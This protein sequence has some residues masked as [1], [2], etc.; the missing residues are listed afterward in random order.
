MATEKLREQISAL[1][2]DELPEGEHELLLRRFTTDVELR[3]HWERYH[4][5]GCALR[6]ELPPVDTRGFAD[7]VMAALAEEPAPAERESSLGQSLI[8]GVAGFAVAA[9]VAV[10]AIVGLQHGARTGASSEIVPD[11]GSAQTV[12]FALGLAN[13]AD[14]EGSDPRDQALLQGYHVDYDVKTASSVPHG[15]PARHY[16]VKP[17]VAPDDTDPPQDQAPP[18]RRQ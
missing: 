4:L 3:L 16:P 10:I 18:P 9:T 2:D 13:D 11:G 17:K 5:V 1:A 6:K 15:L 12:P 7:R 14:W 8:R